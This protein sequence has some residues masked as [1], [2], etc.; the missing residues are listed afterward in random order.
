MVIVIL[1]M[2]IPYYRT[3]IAPWNQ[4]VVQVRDT[5]YTARDIVDRLRMRATD[6]KESR[7]EIATSIIQDLQNREIIKQEAARLNMTVSEQEIDREIRE[8]VKAAATGEGE[9]KE[10]YAS[11]LRGLRL[12]DREFR[13]RV[14]SDLIQQKLFTL[15]LREQPEAEDQVR[16]FAIITGTQERAD[17]IRESLGEGEDF[18]KLAE[19][20]SIDL[21]SAK[22]GGDLGWFPRNVERTEVIGQVRVQG[23]M[24]ETEEGAEEM[25][26]RILDGEDIS[27]LARLN[28]I[29]AS[30]REKEGD[31]G[32]VSADVQSGPPYGAEAY[33]LERGEV[34]E[35]IFVGEGYW[36]VKV[37]DK[38]PEGLLIDDIAFNLEPGQI[39]PPLK[40]I[41]G[42]YII[43]VE[44]REKSH[45]LTMEHRL[46]LTRET[47]NNWLN[48]QSRQGSSEGWIKWNWG[49]EIY[50]WIN[51]QI[52]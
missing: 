36:I 7:F 33:E 44:S 10:V 13:E 45:P 35:P 41:R 38:T 6:A 27:R 16:V 21:G 9:F 12:S 30:S 5:R 8:R 50:S 42:Y 43:Q 20:E 24:V 1:L 40:T 31:L 28:S 22:K 23:L 14:Q 4:A 52:D 26:Q 49:S 3:Y 46:S 34:T 25:R 18:A 47:F 39:S 17:R 29:D 48:A 37:L 11:I 2:A 15:F 32:W 19:E 51:Q